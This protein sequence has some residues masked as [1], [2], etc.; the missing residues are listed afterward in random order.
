MVNYLIIRYIQ[1]SSKNCLFFILI[2][3]AHLE[4]R[5][6]VLLGWKPSRVGD[7]KN[8]KIILPT[9]ANK[10]GLAI[11]KVFRFFQAI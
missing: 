1:K 3:K 8:I 6:Y 9:L 4:T 7:Y 2:A 5:K 10:L 11:F